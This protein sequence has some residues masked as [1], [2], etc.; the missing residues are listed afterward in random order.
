MVNITKVIILIA[1]K[2][3]D[4]MAALAMLADIT[5]ALSVLKEAKKRT[6][7]VRVRNLDLNYDPSLLP[8]SFRMSQT[9]NKVMNNHL[10]NDIHDITSA[11]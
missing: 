4:K 8:P 7:D 9:C 3:G 6:K 1:K 5:R 11:S 2:N 10:N